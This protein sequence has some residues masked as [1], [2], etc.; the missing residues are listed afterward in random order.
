MSRWF[1]FG[2]RLSVVCALTFS[3]VAFAG[4]DDSADA[5]VPGADRIEP[6]SPA[7][8]EI[9]QFPK[10]A[11]SNPVPRALWDRAQTFYDA[12]WQNFRIRRYVTMVNLGAPSSHKR[13][14]ILDLKTGAIQAL[15]TAHGSGSDPN[16]DGI[17]TR[18]SN[19]M[20]SKQ[21][22][23]GVYRVSYVY[24]GS[25]G[26][27][28]HLEGMDSSNNMAWDRGIV[29]HGANYVSESRGRAGTSYGCPALD[30]SYA[31]GVIDKIKDGSI[32]II[33][34]IK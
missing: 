9:Y 20:D 34:N 16:G 8:T 32:L 22:S 30:P 2:L 21:S 4:E 24:M 15:H 7:D 31:Q 23:L 28:A 26:R 10:Y 3:V 27:S 14:W 17:A 12:Q 33:D 29:L 11:T 18:F 5:P 13:F 19:T 25:H 1:H 6:E